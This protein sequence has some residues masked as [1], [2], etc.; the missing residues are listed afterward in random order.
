M[1]VS[2]ERQ[3]MNFLRLC[4]TASLTSS[5]CSAEQ[6]LLL[7]PLLPLFKLDTVPTV[8]NLATALSMVFRFG[9]SGVLKNR[10]YA[11]WTWITDFI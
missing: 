1:P 7:L 2:A 9:A 5:M 6:L 10:R 4:T 11:C 3:Q 8:E